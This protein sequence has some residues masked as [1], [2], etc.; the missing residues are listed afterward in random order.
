MNENI[1]F[2]LERGPKQCRLTVKGSIAVAIRRNM[3]NIACQDLGKVMLDDVSRWTVARCEVRAG[4]AFKNA[5][6]EF[7][8]VM[9]KMCSE[10]CDA[11]DCHVLVHALRSD[12]TNSNHMAG[13]Q[14][15]H[16]GAGIR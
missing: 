13:K 3:G 1:K 5:T 7:F 6:H 8:D 2:E 12:A 14:V 4:N 15:V 10:P 9:R 16:D 11:G